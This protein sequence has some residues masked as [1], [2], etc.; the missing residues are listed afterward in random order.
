MIKNY[1]EF[2]KVDFISPSLFSI[3]SEGKGIEASYLIIT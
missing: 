3:H 1:E 2:L